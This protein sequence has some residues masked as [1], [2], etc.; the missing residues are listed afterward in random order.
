MTIV[1]GINFGAYVVFAADT[2][3]THPNGNVAND[4]CEK[5]QR[6]TIGLIAGA[7]SF[8]LVNRVNNRLQKEK[9]TD[10]NQI[11]GIIEDERNQ[12]LSMIKKEK[13]RYPNKQDVENTNWICSY[14]TIDDGKHKLILCKISIVGDGLEPYRERNLSKK[15]SPGQYFVIM[16]HEV[17]KEY[18][19]QGQYFKKKFEDAI[20]FHLHLSTMFKNPQEVFYGLENL[21]L[22][23]AQLIRSLYYDILLQIQPVPSISPHC[24]IGVHTFK[25]TYIS[26]ILNTTDVAF[27]DK[28]S[29]FY[30]E[31]RKLY[32]T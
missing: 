7:G 3:A 27:K 1:I 16:P 6:T 31:I 25:G 15:S 10:I 29:V 28:L 20:F 19:Q 22:E 5:I 18:E 23:I 8:D 9:V 4:D 12:I 14:P 26:P 13:L 21:S 30:D 11:L 17:N 2:R 24:Q 32:S